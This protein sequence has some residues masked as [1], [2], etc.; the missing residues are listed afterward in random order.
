MITAG[1]P[2]RHSSVLLCSVILSL[3]QHIEDNSLMLE[4]QLCFSSHLVNMHLNANFRLISKMLY[5]APLESL[6]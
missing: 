6:D 5:I 3:Q 4:E 2:V 1:S